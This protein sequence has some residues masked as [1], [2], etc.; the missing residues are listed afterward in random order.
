N[1][2][3]TFR[4]IQPKQSAAEDTEQSVSEDIRRSELAAAIARGLP[5]RR[6]GRGRP[7]KARPD[8]SGASNIGGS[9]QHPAL[10]HR[11]E[12][13]RKQ[14]RAGTRRQRRRELQAEDLASVLRF[15]EEDFAV[16]ERLSNE[17]TWCTPVPHERKVSTVRDFYQ[18]FHDAST[19]PIWTC[20]LCYRRPLAIF[21]S[22]LLSRGRTYLRLCGVYALPEAGWPVASSPTSRPPWLASH[23]VEE[24]LI[25]VNS[26]YG[27][28]TRYSI[29]GGRGQSLRYPRHV[30]GHIT[31]F[32]NNVQELV[33]KVLPHPLLQVMDEIH[34]SWQGAE[35]PGPSDLSSLLS[36]RRRVVERALVW[37][38]KN[39]PHYAEIEIDAA[40]MES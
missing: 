17:Q 11:D 10:T 26:C 22:K 4:Q 28:V 19:L 36:V 27:F 25:A 9:A 38:K 14:I 40:E 7:P 3:P 16:K 39:N 13:P 1:A 29:P 37:L 6:R 8:T 35:K 34:V 30:K 2:A 20:M 5:K 15:L 21:M 31:V 18:A 24:K 23:W 33:T 32:P 12:P